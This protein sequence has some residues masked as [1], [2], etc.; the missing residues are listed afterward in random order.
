[1]S[2]KSFVSLLRGTFTAV[3]DANLIFLHVSFFLFLFCHGERKIDQLVWDI[4]QHALTAECDLLDS[5]LRRY[6]RAPISP[7]MH[8]HKLK[9][10]QDGGGSS[11]RYIFFIMGNVYK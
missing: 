8:Y 10:I 4:E 9:F 5:I 6:K 2:R 1:M 11:S 7:M 3:R